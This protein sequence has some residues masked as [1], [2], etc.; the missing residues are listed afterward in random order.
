MTNG[1]RN[2]NKGHNAERYYAH[3][4]RQLGYHRCATSREG[5]KLYDNA[6]IDL[7]FIPYNIQIKAGKQKNLNAGKELL[8]MKSTITAFFPEDEKVHSLPCLLFHYKEVGKGNK[9]TINDEIVYMSLEQFKS[10]LKDNPI[11][12]YDNLKI[13]NFKVNSEFKEIVSMTFDYF[14]ENIIIKQL[15]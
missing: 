2:R 8:N 1:L 4:F 5:S 14:K 11:L 13:L 3:I 6:K 7:I 9:R 12:K 10:F 15:K